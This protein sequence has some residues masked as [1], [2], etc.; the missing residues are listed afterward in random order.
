MKSFR[1]RQNTSTEYI[2]PTIISMNKL[3]LSPSY[4]GCANIVHLDLSSLPCVSTSKNNDEYI[5]CNASPAFTTFNIILLGLSDDPE[6]AIELTVGGNIHYYKTFQNTK[7]D[8]KIYITETI[9]IIGIPGDIISMTI[10]N[11]ENDTHNFVLDELSRIVT[12]M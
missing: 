3:V 9:P 7:H 10:T 11:C 1:V 2:V 8:G 5:I 4:D 12:I 6:L